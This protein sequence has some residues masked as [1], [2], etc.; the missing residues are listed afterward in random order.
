MFSNAPKVLS[1]SSCSD[2]KLT[3]VRIQELGEVAISPLFVLVRVARDRRS[4]LMI[5]TCSLFVAAVSVH[6]AMLVVI[7]DDIITQVERNPI[8]RW[9]IGLQGGDVWLFVCLKLV[10]TAVVCAVLLTLHELSE[11]LALLASGGVAVLQLI[12][13]SYLSF[14]WH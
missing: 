14:A 5:V 7:N 10:G 2:R 6:D 9:L 4:E 1:A 3:C 12:L 8:G 13:L 11:R